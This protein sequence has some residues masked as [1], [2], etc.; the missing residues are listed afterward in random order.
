[1]LRATIFCNIYFSRKQLRLL[2]VT[3]VFL[4]LKKIEKMIYLKHGR[5]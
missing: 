2:E 4:K 1:M 5:K 3:G